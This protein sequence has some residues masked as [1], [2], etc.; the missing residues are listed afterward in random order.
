MA[1]EVFHLHRLSIGWVGNEFSVNAEDGG[2]S[3]N[4]GAEGVGDA[5]GPH[6]KPMWWYWKTMWAGMSTEKP[7][8]MTRGCTE[9]NAYY[10]AALMIM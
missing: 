5:P 10:S 9:S 3:L 6:S 7:I 8:A 1:T 4:D 2:G